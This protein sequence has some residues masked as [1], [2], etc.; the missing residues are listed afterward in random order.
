MEGSS[1]RFIIGLISG[2]PICAIYYIII[3]YTSLTSIAFFGKQDGDYTA[4]FYILIDCKR[5]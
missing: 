3:H 5:L 1:A 2:Y 4:N